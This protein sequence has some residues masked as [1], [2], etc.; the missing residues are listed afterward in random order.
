MAGALQLSDYHTE[1]AVQ[2]LKQ[3]REV[4]ASVFDNDRHRAKLCLADFLDLDVGRHWQ[5]S[6]SCLIMLSGRNENGVSSPMFLALS[7]GG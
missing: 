6:D 7:N 1:D 2:S 4:L 5:K 3:Y